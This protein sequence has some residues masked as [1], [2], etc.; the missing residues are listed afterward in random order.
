M[1]FFE[2]EIIIRAKAGEKLKIGKS[3]GCLI[4]NYYTYNVVK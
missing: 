1:D 2:K 4:S 3:D